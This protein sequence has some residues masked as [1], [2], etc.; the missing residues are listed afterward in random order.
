[1]ANLFWIRC[2]VYIFTW[3]WKY[4]CQIVLILQHAFKLTFQNPID[5]GSN[6]GIAGIRFQSEITL[7]EFSFS[8]HHDMRL[9]ESSQRR[10]QIAGRASLELT[11]TV[12]RSELGPISLRIKRAVYAMMGQ[13]W[14]MVWRYLPPFWYCNISVWP[15]E[16]FLAWSLSHYFR[17]CHGW[18][19]HSWDYLTSDVLKRHLS[20][21]KLVIKVVYI[22]NIFSRGTFPI[23]AT[24]DNGTYVPK[25]FSVQQQ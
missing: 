15:L 20:F 1:M 10:L 18:P 9:T 3:T 4:R 11:F 7:I 16:R 24:V 23:I 14:E 2:V 22:W 13:V 21:V 19:L 6:M 25:R 5:S 8:A 12:T 17:Y